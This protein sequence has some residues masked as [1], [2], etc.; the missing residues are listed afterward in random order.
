VKAGKAK[1]FYHPTALDSDVIY[2]HL[3]SD[4]PPLQSVTVWAIIKHPHIKGVEIAK[5]LS[6]YFDSNQFTK[7]SVQNF[8]YEVRKNQWYRE[9]IKSTTYGGYWWEW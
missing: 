3:K 5:L 9:R 6:L 1:I 4:L 2:S 8:V 7:I